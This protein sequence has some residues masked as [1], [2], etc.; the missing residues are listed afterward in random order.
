MQANVWLRNE[1]PGSRIPATLA[2]GAGMEK[3]QRVDEPGS[4]CGAV[5]AID[6]GL[7]SLGL[8]LRFNGV[9]ADEAQIA[10][11]FGGRP[12]GVNDMLRCARDFKL[13]AGAAKV[14]WARLRRLTLP[15]IA[16]YGDGT[17]IVLARVTEDQALIQSPARGRPQLVPRSQ[18]EAE[19]SGRLV[20]MVRRASLGDFARRFDIA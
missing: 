19:W 10:H 1:G 17:F 20:V 13:K 9:A 2:A 4:P 11:R 3:S 12:I 6:G 5:A 16:E 14:D 8:L 7:K 15:A 18:F